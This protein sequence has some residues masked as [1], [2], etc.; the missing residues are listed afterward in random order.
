M[1]PQASGSGRRCP[2]HQKESAA[3]GSEGGF[4]GILPIC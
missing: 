2:Q 3:G 4:K 1:H